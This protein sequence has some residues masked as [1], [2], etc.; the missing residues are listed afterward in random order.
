MCYNS[1]ARACTIV[2]AFFI[3]LHMKPELQQN[4]CLNKIK[5]NIYF[6]AA[7]ILLHVKPH[8]YIQYLLFL[9]DRVYYGAVITRLYWF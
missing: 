8:T 6:I 4:K 1:P 3:L 2:A 9:K 7:F 5:Q